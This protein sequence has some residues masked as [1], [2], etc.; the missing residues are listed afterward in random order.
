MTDDETL[1]DLGDHKYT[2]VPWSKEDSSE[3]A[4]LKLVKSIWNEVNISN[5]KP[6]LT[7]LFDYYLKMVWDISLSIPTEY[8]EGDLFEIPFNEQFY[9]YKISNSPKGQASSLDLK[10]GETLN[11]AL[12]LE[13]KSTDKFEVFIDE[14]KL[15]RPIVFENLPVSSNSVKKPMVFVGYYKESFDGRSIDITGGPLEFKAYLFWNS[16]IAPVEH[17]GSLIRIHNA[18]GTL[19]DETFLKYQVQEVTRKTK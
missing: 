13:K 19:F 5:P 10:I 7:D 4:F 2:S 6:K 9:T 16:K 3:T 17:Q 11:D 1:K 18:S 12:G 14:L 8:I 15:F